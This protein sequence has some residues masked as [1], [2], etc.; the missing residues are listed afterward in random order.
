MGQKLRS[1]T[2]S[3]EH[4]TH[5]LPSLVET[6]WSLVSIDLTEELLSMN[7]EGDSRDSNFSNDS[8]KY[9]ASDIAD[10]IC[11]LLLSLSMGSSICCV[12]TSLDCS[13]L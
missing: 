4:L 1:S 11:D 3:E 8:L 13:H 2:K 9:I 7:G 5:F 6:A 10:S 12:A